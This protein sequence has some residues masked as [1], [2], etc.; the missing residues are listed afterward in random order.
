M[1]RPPRFPALPGGFLDAL[2]Q[3]VGEPNVAA[4]PAELWAYATDASDRVAPP[5]AVVRPADVE[6]VVGVVK[7]CREFGVSLT[8][9]GAG[10]SFAGQALNLT[11]GLVLDA[12]RM[13]RIVDVDVADRV[14][15]AQ[16][17]VLYEKINHALA[18]VGFFFPPEPGS[19]KLCTLG[20][21]VGNNASGMRS[22][23]YGPTRDHVLDL[24]VVLSDG[25]V[26]HTGSRCLKSAATYGLTGLF[27]GSEGTLGVITEVTLKITPLPGFRET[28]VASFTDARAATSCAVEVQKRG[29]VPSAMELLTDFVISQLEQ[30]FDRPFPDEAKAP[31]GAALLVEVDGTTEEGVA[32]EARLVEETLR[33]RAVEVRRAEG[34][35]ERRR[36]WDARHALGQ[37]L[38][39]IRRG[40]MTNAAIMD[41]G[42][43][44]SKVPDAVEALREI[45]T[46]EGCSK[47]VTVYGHVG[48]GNL[49]VGTTIDERSPGGREVARNTTRAVLDAVKKLGGTLSAEHGTGFVKA[50]FLEEVAGAG[51]VALMRAV[52]RALDPAGLF[53]PGQMGLDFGPFG[54]RR[55]DD[56][57]VKTIDGWLAARGEGGESS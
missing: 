13:N 4:D 41:V 20:G 49:H 3:V 26:V 54:G 8:P 9:R 18:K 33:E 23:K 53:N 52:K 17:G 5:G 22:V 14:V 43:P 10:T 57:F 34:E 42:V 51:A 27:V 44:L 39:K 45:T 7:A 16:P 6:E 1:G 19:A 48:D 56:Q 25:S 28:F 36:F 2:R 30:D 11:G 55:P 35:E 15:V 21:M 31:G 50:P 40:L 12:R 32:A 29:V 46:R 37:R 24:E 38:T 47:F